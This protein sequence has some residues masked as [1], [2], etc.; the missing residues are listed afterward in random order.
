[1]GLSATAKKKKYYYYY[2]QHRPNADVSHLNA[3]SC[4]LLEPSC[5]HFQ[6]QISKALMTK[7]LRFFK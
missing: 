2:Y 5:W 3:V 7:H 6:K 1:L 4:D